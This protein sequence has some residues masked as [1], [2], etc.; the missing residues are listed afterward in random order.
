[1]KWWYVLLALFLGIGIVIA[2]ISLYQESYKGTLEKF[3]LVGGD[4]SQAV[5]KEKTS[6]WQAELR[7]GFECGLFNRMRGAAEFMLSGDSEQGQLSFRL[8]EARVVC[9]ASM[10]REG[11]IEVGTYEV[12]KGLGYLESGYRWVGERGVVDLRVCE[13]LPDNQVEMVMGELLSST[14]GRV[15]DLLYEKWGEIVSL[16]EPVEIMCIDYRNS[17]R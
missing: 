14:V 6:S 4:F 10:M 9:G 16:R 11:K 15:H 1:M 12:M 13:G 8:A 17:R 5:V 3:G 2:S 7:S